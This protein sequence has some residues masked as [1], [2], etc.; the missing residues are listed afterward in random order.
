MTIGNRRCCEEGWGCKELRKRKFRPSWMASLE[1]TA[2]RDAI[3][4]TRRQ[5]RHVAGSIRVIRWENLRDRRVLESIF[6][7]SYIDR[8]FEKLDRVYKTLKRSSFLLQSPS[9]N[10][11][12]LAPRLG[13]FDARF[14]DFFFLW[15]FFGSSSDSAERSSC[16]R[17]KT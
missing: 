3:R 8:C 11:V 5:L 7:I 2:S 15:R 10:L 12:K 4:G 14:F 16:G 13:L 9:K 17:F 1:F 6:Q